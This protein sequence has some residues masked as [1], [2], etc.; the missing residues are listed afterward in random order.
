[1]GSVFNFLGKYLKL[2][3]ALRFHYAMVF[4]PNPNPS[5]K[6]ELLTTFVIL[7]VTMLVI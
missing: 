1:M 2:C 6:N 5:L 3:S 4:M 7:F